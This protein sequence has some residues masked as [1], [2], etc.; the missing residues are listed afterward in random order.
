MADN[1]A[2]KRT[3]NSDGTSPTSKTKKSKGKNHCVSC[4]NAVVDDAVE[5]Q[6]CGKWEHK[7]CVKI[8]DEEYEMI[9]QCSQNILFFCSK[10]LLNLPIAMEV[11]K[12]SENLDSCFKS[13]ERELSKSIVGQILD[14][15]D[16][17]MQKLDQSINDVCQSKIQPVLQKCDLLNT[18]FKTLESKLTL[19]EGELSS[20]MKESTNN[21]ESIDKKLDSKSDSGMECDTASAVSSPVKSKTQLSKIVSSVLN[22]EKDKARRRLNLIVHGVPESQSDTGISRRDD[23]INFVSSCLK[24][25]LDISVTIEKAFRFGKRSDTQPDRPRLLKITLNSERDKSIILKRC[26]KLRNSENPAHIR[27]VFFTPDLT[28]GELELN[29]KLRADLKEKNKDKNLYRIKNGKIV[30]RERQTT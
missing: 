29:K 24:D 4:G 16:T 1:V 9:D 19:M 6:W 7:N 20:L 5:C 13:L 3:R 28:P 18:N 25:H 22:E 27:K 8:S 23:D 15:F 11:S 26:A 30:L 2:S 10:C 12:I 21:F 17:I 14:N